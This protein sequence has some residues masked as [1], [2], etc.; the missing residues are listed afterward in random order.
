MSALADFLVEPGWWDLPRD[1]DRPDG[2][3]ADAIIATVMDIE[4][5]QVSIHQGNLRHAR[6]YAGYTP[7]ALLMA[8]SA[9]VSYRQPFEATKALVRSVCD[10]ATSLIVKSR[11]KPSIVTDGA[12]WKVQQQAEE[13]DQFLVGAYRVGGMYKVAPRT[14]HDSTVF[15]TG[16]WKYVPHGRGEDFRVNYERVFPDD[17]IVDEDESREHLMPVNVY[18]RTVVRVDALIKRYAKGNDALARLLVQR[19]KASQNLPSW[20]TLNVPRGH[21]VLVEAFHQ[22]DVPSERRRVLAVGGIV[23]EDEVWPHDFHPFT[24]LW[25]NLP[26]SGYYGD[27]VAYRQYG[28]QQRITYMHKWIQ[29]V[30]DL[31]ATP[32]AWV[33]P[34]G[35]PP[36]LQM[37]NDIGKVIMARRPPVFQTQQIVN[38]EVYRWLD[39][40]E[41]DGYEDEGV[42]Q[43]TS[44]NQLPPGVD[45]APAQREYSYKEG[46]RFAPVSQRWEDAIAVEAAEKTIA[47]YAHHYRRSNVAAKVRWADRKLVH[48]IE[49]PEDLDAQ[50]YMIRPEA[51]S[52]DSLS[53]AARTQQALE[54]AQTGWVSPQEGRA[55]LAHPDL[56]E[57]DELGNAGMTYAKWVARKL[58]RGEVVLVDEKADL[59]TLLDVVKKTRLLAVTKNAPERIVAN[60]DRYLESLDTL[61]KEAEAAA[62][63]Q[64]MAQAA[65]AA[66]TPGVSEASAEGRPSPF[67]G[68]DGYT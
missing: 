63:E 41:G 59:A 45:S 61:L 24:T 66:P 35:G 26:L 2:P 52:L 54:L 67:A 43:V 31:F 68:G 50:A 28:R 44:G 30:L 55:L 47:M 65:A 34:V 48:E 10:T 60:F 53:P 39:K 14:F 19:L 32:T 57:S 13:L 4:R 1:P 23:L 42:S 5:R 36:T 33:D 25:W 38:P 40:L 3:L 62:Q 17:F 64:M 29:R 9:G 46:Q 18:H 49:W 20:P 7:S 16:V 21:T 12:D 15:G 56:V 27:G 37:S 8:G 11:P 6:I 58:W 22:S 51:S